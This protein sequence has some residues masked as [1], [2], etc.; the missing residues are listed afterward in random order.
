M[1]MDKNLA[2]DEIA[3]LVAELN[4]HSYR[5]YVLDNPTISD[6][7][8]DMK[9]NR[10]K[11]LESAF[12]DLILPYSPTQRVGGV[13]AGQFEKV[14]HTVQMGSLQDVFSFEEI[15]AFDNRC[16]EELTPTYVVEAK[17]D[18]LSVSLE[19]ENGL[20]VRGSTRGDGFVG[21]DVT[22]NLRT[23]S[24]IPL[25]LNESVEYLEVRGEVY[26]PKKSFEQ[27]V[28]AQE[29][30]GEEP[31]KNPRNAAAG[32]LRQKDSKITASRKLD[33]FVFN[34][35]QCRGK[36]LTSHAQSLDWLRDLGFKV[37]P[38]YHS[39]TDIEEVISDIMQ[40]G[41]DRDGFSFDIDGAV[42]KVD[43][44]AQRDLLGATAKYPRW[45]VAFK[46]PPEEKETVLRDIEIS[47]GRTGKIV[48]TAWL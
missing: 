25:K 5:Y 34:V 36:K 10:L 16:R 2:K 30:R 23:I 4:D 12:P 22:A 13:A 44:L 15:R 33:I 7:D 26:M 19:Y 24:S 39:F 43:D 45:A 40:I 21:E 3:Q 18:G 20:F 31:A 28:A 17:I 41:D 8:Y 38:R 35:Q 6:Y 9:Q 29:L 46:Y 47:V 14:S 42:V 27:L 32:A 1:D 48:P 11:Q 37:S